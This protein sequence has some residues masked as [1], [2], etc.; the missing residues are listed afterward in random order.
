MKLA[1]VYDVA[2]KEREQKLFDINNR[3][4][5]ARTQ[6]EMEALNIAEQQANDKFVSNPDVQ[7]FLQHQ[8][9]LSTNYSNSAEDI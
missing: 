9:I 4:K 3:R 6:G 8:E 1:D 5:V 7:Q 2:Y